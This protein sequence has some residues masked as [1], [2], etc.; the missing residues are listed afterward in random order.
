M[1]KKTPLKRTSLKK[2]PG[3]TLK[4]TVLKSKPSSLKKG[5]PLKKNSKSE[6][7]LKADKLKRDKRNAFW[8]L[9][10]DELPRWSEI[11]GVKFKELNRA[12]YHH[13]YPKSKYPTIEFSLKVILCVT[14]EEHQ[15]V[16]TNLDY[17]PVSEERRKYI[18]ENWQEIEEE[19]SRWEEEFEK[20]LLTKT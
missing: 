20:E 11:S 12:H 13:V 8:Q 4:K 17:Y 7:K 16:E 18:L 6:E 5:V 2:K 9:C 19:S 10:W 3:T 1:L 14:F 15:K